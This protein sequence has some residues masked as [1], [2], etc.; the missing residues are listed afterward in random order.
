M[1]ELLQPIIDVAASRAQF[2]EFGGDGAA[3]DRAAAADG[4][5]QAPPPPAANPAR[6]LEPLVPTANASAAAVQWAEQ[7][8]L[9]ATYGAALHSYAQDVA[10][11]L[12]GMS[13]ADRAAWEQG[14]VKE[15]GANVLIEKYLLN[16]PY[17]AWLRSSGVLADAHM[18]RLLAP[19]ARQLGS[20]K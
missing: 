18:L 5:T 3:F 20:D 14:Q 17:A 1:T 19:I 13:P 11:K 12:A 2:V 7:L 4:Y 16:G 9:P 8:G 10:S 6:V 15:A